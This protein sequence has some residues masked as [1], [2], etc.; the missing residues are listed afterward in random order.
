VNLPGHA[1]PL[2]ITAKGAPSAPYVRG[3]TIDGRAVGAPIIRHE[4]I[5]AGAD[6]QFEMS[7]V[8]ETWGGCSF[9]CEIIPDRDWISGVGDEDLEDDGS[10][11][12]PSWRMFVMRKRA[13]VCSGRPSRVSYERF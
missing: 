2:I 5:A 10:L 3:L 1:K 6:V 12:F 13:P 8:P 4:Q 11:C 9:L 7:D